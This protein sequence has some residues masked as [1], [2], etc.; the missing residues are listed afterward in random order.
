MERKRYNAV[1]QNRCGEAHLHRYKSWENSKFEA[2]DSHDKCRRTSAITASTTWLCSSEKRMQTIAWRAPGKNPTRIQNHS[3]QSTNKT[4]KRQQ[5][6]ATKNMT[7]RLTLKQIEGS[8]TGR[9]ETCR[10][11]GQDRGPT[12][13]QLRQRRQRGTKPIGRRAI[14]TLSILQAL[15]TGIFLRVRTGFG[16]LET[17]TAC[18][19]LHSMITFHHANTSGSRAAKLRIAHLCVPKKLSSTCHVSFLAAPDTD[20]KHKFCLTHFIHFSYLSDSLTFAHTSSMVLDPYL[21][22]DVPW[23]SG[24]S[25]QIPS[26]T[27]RPDVITENKSTE[28]DSCQ[29]WSWTS[30]PMCKLSETSEWWTSLS[31]SHDER[32]MTAIARSKARARCKAMANAKRYFVNLLTPCLDFT[33]TFRAHKCAMMTERADAFSGPGCCWTRLDALNCLDKNQLAEMTS[34]V[35]E[36]CES[37][38]FCSRVLQ[39]QSCN[40]RERKSVKIHTCCRQWQT[41]HDVHTNTVAFSP[42]VL[43]KCSICPYRQTLTSTPWIDN[44]SRHLTQSHIISLDD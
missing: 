15:T 25:T 4:A 1:R 14:G 43:I 39:H 23:Q 18:T 30:R 28:T 38:R 44:D 40:P 29:R 20:N 9:G 6:E 11:L 8:T 2:L 32:N 13:K 10:K 3:S 34:S 42:S 7:T 37:F 22:C 16:C 33:I 36:C 12:C 19:V 27:Q 24:G 35:F 26:L 17:N 31:T 21:P 5:F 41:V